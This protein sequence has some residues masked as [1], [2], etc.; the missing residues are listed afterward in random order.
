MKRDEFLKYCETLS[1]EELHQRAQA[2]RD[3]GIPLSPEALAQFHSLDDVTQVQEFSLKTACTPDPKGTHIYVVKPLTPASDRLPVVINVHGGGW[4]KPHSDRD[5]HFC[6]RLANKLGCLVVDVD[7]VLA[8]EYPYP[9]A[10]KEIEALLNELPKFLPEWGGN[11][12]NVVF[13]GQSAGG[14][15]LGGVSHRKK[16]TKDLT[17][18]AQILAYSPCDN[19][20]NHF[21]D[22]DLDQR[23]MATEYYGFYYNQSMEERKNSDVSLTFATTEDL[24]GIPPT[25]VIT[26]GQDNLCPEAKR[27]FELLQAHGVPSTYRCFEQS[28]HGFVINLVDEWQEAETY[29]LGLL[30]TY[31]A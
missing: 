1:K 22:A 19:Y 2:D 17:V 14:N 31:F 24:K 28:R 13:C 9:A 21:G 27:Y 11:P 20:S 15:L 6:R 25:D 26:G 4:C 10:L 3:R 29:I 5:L 30:R 8:P 23:G 18:K 12:K 7:Y 16:Y